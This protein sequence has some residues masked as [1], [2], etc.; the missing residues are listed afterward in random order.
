M[1]LED[2]VG[3]DTSHAIWQAIAHH[4][5]GQNLASIRAVCRM[6]RKAVDDAV[7]AM[8]VSG[9]PLESLLPRRER[10]PACKQYTFIDAS[11]DLPQYVRQNC[12]SPSKQAGVLVCGASWW[13]EP[14]FQ[15]WLQFSQDQSAW[16][17]LVLRLCEDHQ[18]E[19][20]SAYLGQILAVCGVHLSLLG[21]WCGVRILIIVVLI[22][23]LYGYAN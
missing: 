7:T 17:G 16:V 18:D 1:M 22:Y 10:F 2:C 15:D 20:L 12:G 9:D 6:S 14:R 23:G 4:L 3:T 21:L 13:K 19:D 8:A 11:E 5:G